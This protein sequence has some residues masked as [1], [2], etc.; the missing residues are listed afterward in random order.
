M[1]TVTRTLLQ[2]APAAAASSDTAAFFG[3]IGAASA[4]VFACPSLLATDR[5][6]YHQ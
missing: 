2:D 5:H 1:D 6:R 3:F 4:L